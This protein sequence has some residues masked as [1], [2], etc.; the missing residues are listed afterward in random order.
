[1]GDP[2]GSPRV[3]PLFLPHRGPFIFYFFSPAIFFV[4][5]APRRR[6][7]FTNPTKFGSL[8]STRCTDSDVGPTCPFRTGERH[9]HEKWLE[10]A[11]NEWIFSP[12][13]ALSSYASCTT[14]WR[15]TG[16]SRPYAVGSVG[17]KNLRPPDAWNHALT[18]HRN[19]YKG[20][21]HGVTNGCDHTSTNAPDPIRTPKLSVFGRE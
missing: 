12:R 14:A 13:T 1:M 11:R 7:T 8:R 4:L 5:A 9:E 3:A 18:P 10:H 20:I 15:S 2:L 21:K 17:V 16:A 6:R 19:S